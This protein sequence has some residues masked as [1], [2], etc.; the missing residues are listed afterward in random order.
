ML[1]NHCQK[2]NPQPL[3]SLDI[4]AIADHWSAFAGSESLAPDGLRAGLARARTA[5][6]SNVPAW[7]LPDVLDALATGAANV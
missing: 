4:E 3:P 7:R 1:S 5:L 6:L 2:V